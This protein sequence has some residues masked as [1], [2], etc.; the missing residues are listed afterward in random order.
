MNFLEKINYKFDSWSKERN[1]EKD[2]LLLQNKDFTIISNNCWGGIIYQDLQL[3]YLSP[4]VNLYMFIPCYIKF[5]ENLEFYLNKKLDFTEESKYNQANINKIRKWYP[6]GKL[7]DI[8]LH[9]I[10]YD[11]VDI[12]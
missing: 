2:R 10:H 9:F 8:E 7:D 1:L 3:P 4:T 11:N 12:A 5:L 6:I